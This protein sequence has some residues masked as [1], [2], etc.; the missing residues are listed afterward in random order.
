[1]VDLCNLEVQD[2]GRALVDPCS[3]KTL[4]LEPRN[5][6]NELRSR[7]VYCSCQRRFPVSVLNRTIVSGFQERF[8]VHHL[9]SHLPNPL[10]E[11]MVIGKPQTTGID[12]EVLLF[13]IG[14]QI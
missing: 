12:W 1:M 7:D 11:D 3:I 4:E 9:R 2:F 14:L 13:T 8:G 10:P 5:S 6:K